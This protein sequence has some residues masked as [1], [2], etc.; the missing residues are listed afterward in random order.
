MPSS[1]SRV[2][3]LRKDAPDVRMGISFQK[4]SS[5][6]HI[7]EGSEAHKR[8]V[9][10]PVIRAVNPAGL[11]AAAGLHVGDM[12]LTINGKEVISNLNAAAMLREA[13]GDIKIVVRS[14]MPPPDASAS[15]A[16][17][18]NSA[19]E[20]VPPLALDPQPSPPG[21]HG[22]GEADTAAGSFTARMFG[23]ATK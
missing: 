15:A 6:M 18:P 17:P 3:R 10:P 7:G 8:G 1:D 16:P 13:Q 22:A 19:A 2:V 12:V 20:A 11:A 21:A 23:Q 9:L 5:P 14:V 4:D